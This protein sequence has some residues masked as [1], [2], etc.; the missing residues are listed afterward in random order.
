MRYRQNCFSAED[1]DALAAYTVCRC[2]VLCCALLCSAVLCCALLCS[3]VLPTA[4]DVVLAVDLGCW[5]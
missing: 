3:A 5:R 1:L 2:A 4:L